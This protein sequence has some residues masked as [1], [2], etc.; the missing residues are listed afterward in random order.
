MFVGLYQMKYSRE[1]GEWLQWFYGLLAAIFQLIC[2]ILAGWSSVLVVSLSYIPGMII[3]YQ[4]VHE[5]GQKLNKNEKITFAVITA[6][7]I[8]SI[9]LIANGTISVL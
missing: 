2:M 8:L 7:C 4:C 3:Y 1:H 6:L 9:V 5:K